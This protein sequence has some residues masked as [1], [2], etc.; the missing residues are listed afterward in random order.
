ME[1]YLPIVFAGMMGL[2]L[3]IYVILDGYDLGIGLLLPLGKEEQKDMMIAAIGPF[4]D[5]NETWIVF[6]VGILLVAFP[7]AHGLVL[8]T[9]YLPVSVMLIGL[10]LRGIAFDFRAKAVAAH[11]QRWNRLFTSGSLLATCAQGWMLGSYITGLR[12]D[13]TGLL[14]SALIAIC[15]PSLY[16]MLGAAWLLIKAE[17]DLFDRACH[18]ARRAV[19]PMGMTLL[20]VSIATPLVSSTIADKWFSWPAFLQLLPIPALSTVAYGTMLWLLFRGRITPHS[21]HWLLYACLILICILATAGLAYSILPDIVI[22]RMTVMQAAASPASLLFTFWGTAIVLPTVLI[23]TLVVY[24][25]FRGKAT[26]LTY[27]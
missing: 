9:L 27:D 1:I 12:Q 24:R 4:W 23:Y 6:G 13:M 8:S 11:K 19:L 10:V 22:D 3:L 2:S 21:R 7:Q 15:L 18:W 25:I 14:F 26:P 5:A 16:V 17:G 20:L